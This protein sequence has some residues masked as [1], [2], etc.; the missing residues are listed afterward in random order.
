MHSGHSMVGPVRRR[1]S[2][3]RALSRLAVIAFAGL[4]LAGCSTLN[5][6]SAKE[7][8]P[9]E[10]PADK[11]YNNA[12]FLLNEERNFKD[13]AKKFEEVD[14]QHPYSEWARK[15]LIMSAY[16]YYAGRQ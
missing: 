5:I 6:F 3:A 4:L 12:V 10:E 16:S 7:E 14:R 2:A 8:Q 13:A 9:P 11:L 15:A 1:N